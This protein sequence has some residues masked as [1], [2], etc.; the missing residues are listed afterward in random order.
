[1]IAKVGS[2]EITG[3]LLLARFHELF[4]TSAQIFRAPGRVNLIGEHTDYNDGYVMPMAIGFYTWVAAAK[5][6][7]RMIEVYSEHFDEKISLSMDALAGPPR[8]H[9]SDF[10][11]GVAAELEE[12]GHRL[13]GANLVIHGE[14]PLGAGLSSSAS[15]EVS[16]ALA[17]TS[18]S[19]APV[20]RLDLARLCQ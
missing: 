13:S 20:P 3:D 9:W 5:R 11:R 4:G 7:D 12:A 15:L 10:I 16:V 17:L 1:M 19:G 6:S 8:K 14:I 18:L 2:P